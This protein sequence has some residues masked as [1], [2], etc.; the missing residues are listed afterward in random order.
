MKKALSHADLLAAL[1]YDPETGIWTRKRCWGKCKKGSAV[2]YV[3]THGYRKIKL[4]GKNYYS[5]RLA[6]F[7]VNSNWPT[8]EI[9]HI[10]FNRANDTWNNLRAATKQQNR[11]H[12]RK[13][14]NNTSSIKGVSWDKANKKW[15][16]Q[17]TFNKKNHKL[18]RFESCDLA[19]KA[20]AAAAKHYFG[21]FACAG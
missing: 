20:Y 16:A 18:G 14:K 10:D 13:R 2:G 12:L 19:Q 1:H 15:V 8:E 3:D 11:A 9:D 17:L 21:E 7:Y 4:F 5:G 6:F